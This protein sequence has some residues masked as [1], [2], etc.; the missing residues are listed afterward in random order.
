[1]AFSF[2]TCLANFGLHAAG[3]RSV[4]TEIYKIRRQDAQAP[5]DPH[6][7][8]QRRHSVAAFDVADKRRVQ[9]RG[10]GEGLLGHAGFEAKLADPGAECGGDGEVFVSAGLGH[11]SFHRA[12]PCLT[13]AY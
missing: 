7:R 12:R 1:M 4:I 11:A 3:A 13:I 2:S 5:G 9:T 6:D 10:F 8:R